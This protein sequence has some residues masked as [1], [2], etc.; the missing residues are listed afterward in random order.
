MSDKVEATKESVSEAQEP[1]SEDLSQSGSQEEILK[2]L[3]ELRGE[4][5]GLQQRQD[6]LTNQFQERLEKLG[7]ELTPEQKTADRILQL[8]E[9]LASVVAPALA[10]SEAQPTATSPSN[11][12]FVATF[13]DVG[14]LQPTAADYEKAKTFS[15]AN[16]MKNY[17]GEQQ[18]V[19]GQTPASAATV[20]TPS[21]GAPTTPATEQAV[22][23]YIKNY[24][25][26][27]DAGNRSLAVDLKRQA[28]KDGIEV[29][30]IVFDVNI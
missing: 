6:K 30:D 23:D 4:V 9:N 12:D 29:N 18:A 16:E 19:S 20:V 26:A 3:R 28:R 8:E 13:K 21:G 27:L 11:I 10:S 1:V 14:I 2:E 24:T 25:E 15:D 17:F 5:G 7:V 22:T